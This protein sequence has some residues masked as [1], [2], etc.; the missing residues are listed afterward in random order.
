MQVAVTG[1]TG[2]IGSSLARELPQRGYHVRAL[3]RRPLKAPRSGCYPIIIGDLRQLHGLEAAFAGID[4]VI[5]TAAIT[6]AISDATEADYQAI[7]TEGT[8]ELA[9]AAQHAGV[10]R[11]IFLSSISAQSGP[12]A[13]VVLTEE[14]VPA[15][16][17]AYGRSKLAAEQGLS[18]LAIDWVALR[19]VSVYGREPKGKLIP[20]LRLARSPLPLPVGGLT[21]RRSLLFLDNL[22]AAIDHTLRLPGPLRRPL[23]VSDPGALSIPEIV[24]AMR[25][26]LG[27]RPGIIWVPR[28]L[29]KLLASLAGYGGDYDRF[30]AA[31]L[32]ASSGALLRSGWVPLVRSE[33]WLAAMAGQSAEGARVAL[34]A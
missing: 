14:V 19:P 6:S 4:S 23:I 12:T 31:S 20:L 34:G 24:T 7:N 1:A 15:P 8:L 9:K 28:P 11:F 29:L 26:G 30:A 17:N 18:E 3:V 2:F 5:H 32:I 13:N 22:I 33:E 10:S 27:R 16:V 25:R 21:S